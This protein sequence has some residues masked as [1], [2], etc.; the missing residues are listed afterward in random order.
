MALNE[1]I[2]TRKKSFSHPHAKTVFSTDALEKMSKY[3][4]RLR[5]R[6]GNI[7]SLEAFFTERESQQPL[8]FLR[9]VFFQILLIFIIYNMMWQSLTC[10][11]PQIR[12]IFEFLSIGFIIT[13][14]TH[15]HLSL[16][17]AAPSF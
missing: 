14:S 10:R 13:R 8:V 17:A 4:K 11:S 6:I 3:P 5:V 1:L 12:S 2:G 9:W 16:Q 15:S 7:N